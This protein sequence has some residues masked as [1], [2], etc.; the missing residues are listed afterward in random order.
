MDWKH[1]RQGKGQSVE[2]F[3]QEFRK[4]A[5]TLDIPLKTWETLLK[6][7]GSFHSY[8]QHSLFMFNP[9]EFDE[10]CIQDI[11]IEAGGKPFQSNFSKKSFKHSENKDSKEYKG[12]KSATA[13]KEGER[14]TCSHFQRVGHDE[15]KCWKLHLKLKPKKFLKKNGGMKSNV[16]IQQ[17]L[18]S[19]SDD[20]KK[21]IVMGLIGN[22]SE[23]SSISSCSSYSSK[24]NNLV[25]EDK[26]IE[27]FHIR[28]ISKQTQIDTLFDIG[29]Q[30]NLICEKLVRK[31][32]LEAKD[33]P[34]PYPLGQLKENTQMHVKKQ[35]RLRFAITA[36]FVDEVDLDVIPLDICG[37]VLGSPYLYYQ[38]TI[39]DR[40]EH[41]YHL[42]KNGIEYVI[43]AHRL[44]TNLDL[45]NVSQMKRL[46][47]SSKKY[48]LMFVKKQPKD[49]YDA[50]QGCDSQFKV[51]LVEIVD[52]YT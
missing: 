49:N 2:E 39:F 48:F 43:K 20:E 14:P 33:H 30:E 50:F 7:I 5:L 45:I 24:S 44:K 4:K 17:D 29:S 18:G 15:S 46:I 36:N 42:F 51:K 38:D 6:Y 28:I 11:H 26:R 25:E 52:S 41:K 22:P 16:A 9:T 27:Q 35:C 3:T 21:I 8:L 34:K 31:L 1:L 19:D 37:V 12:N 47:S 40:K 13:K 23:A 32:G 10:L